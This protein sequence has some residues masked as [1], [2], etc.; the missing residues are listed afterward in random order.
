ME[1]RAR[2]NC[3]TERLL[4][5]AILEKGTVLGGGIL[6]VDS[7]L[8]HQVDAALI[9]LVGKHIAKEFSS[10]QVDKVFTAESSGIA[11]ALAVARQIRVPMV[12]ARKKRPITMSEPVSESAPSHTKGGTVNLYVSAEFLEPS[13]NILIVDD[14]LA[15]G[16]TIA[17][18][19]RII[20]KSGANLVGIAAV[21]EKSF[22]GG[23]DYLLEKFDVPVFGA[24]RIVSLESGRIVFEDNSCS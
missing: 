19:G 14:F 18:L 11:P 23:R 10:M 1:S 9:D 24:A 16:L 13:D 5:K 6:K 3:Y 4:R 20:A 12:F 22:E 7:F 21:I 15:S 2:E 8:N 17:A